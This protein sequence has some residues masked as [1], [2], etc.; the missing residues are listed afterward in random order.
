M[1]NWENT[2]ITSKGLALLAK[3]IEGHSLAIT[4]AVSGSGFVTPGTLQNQT[5]V[6]S[7]VQ[8]LRLRSISYP[9]DGKCE[10]RCYLT[11]ENLG[12]SYTANQVGVYAN[13]PDEGEILFFI[14]QSVSANSG[15]LV[16][17]ET[18]MP[19]FTAEWTF[20]FKYGQASNV[21][22]V[23]DPAHTVT[24]EEM[25]EYV[26]AYVE[27]AINPLY[28]TKKVDGDTVAVHDSADAPFPAINIRGKS[29]QVNTT[30]KN[31]LNIKDISPSETASLAWNGDTVTV[32]GYIASMAVYGL[33]IG[34]TYTISYNSTRTGA[35]GGGFSIEFKGENNEKIRGV[36]K[37]DEFGN[38]SYTFQVPEGTDRMAF[39]LYGTN[40]PTGEAS[41]TYA[42][43]QLELGSVATAY[44]TYTGGAPA[45]S[46]AY[47]QD[48]VHAGADGEIEVKV[49][50]KNLLDLSKVT[51]MGYE[52]ISR[53]GNKITI[54]E[55]DYIYGLK[56]TGALPNLEVGKTYA[57]S[58]DYTPNHGNSWGYRYKTASGLW[59]KTNNS[60]K[61]IFK[62]TEPIVDINFYVGFNITLTEPMVISNLQCEVGEAVT[63]FEEYKEQTMAVSTPNGMAG[64]DS[65]CDEK[66]SSNGIGLQRIKV[67]ELTGTEN[68]SL[69]TSSDTVNQFYAVFKDALAQQ[70]TKNAISNMFRG[71]PVSQRKGNF[72][73]VYTADQS[74]YSYVCVNT[75]DFATVIEWKAFLA[76]KYAAGTPVKVWYKLA[77]PIETPL[78]NEEIAAYKALTSY[79]PN[80]TV[81]ND[82]GADMHVEYV[83][84][85]HEGLVGMMMSTI[86]DINAILE[87]VNGGE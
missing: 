43:V 7:P 17:S 46:I 10:L 79:N 20:Y 74:G 23:I 35:T 48:V 84:Q 77:T 69:Y 62:V 26:E 85:T 50:G 68:W 61:W 45:P 65:V 39:F 41:A 5:A 66:D 70:Y 8:N 72:G 87:S 58:C 82:S 34:E 80:T 86:G 81:L 49:C 27:T 11:N 47:P 21:T 36:Y 16:P 24:R 30:G 53:D 28:P 12:S 22:I 13:D 3:L 15:T 73:T 56:L 40:A 63:E 64:F 75:M 4:K 6:K 31:L 19:S 67:V 14:A 25:E 37:T 52:N 71:I 83:T 44:E 29:T 33:T 2:V 76:E 57:F 59:S 9:E 54:T 38:K 55:G 51:K 60:N 42:Y 78:S 32:T 1:N 18:E